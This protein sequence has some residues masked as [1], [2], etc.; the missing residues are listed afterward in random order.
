MNGSKPLDLPRILQMHPDGAKVQSFGSGCSS[1][2]VKRSDAVW[3]NTRDG[4]HHG[5]NESIGGCTQDFTAAGSRVRP[6]HSAEIVRT[7]SVRTTAFR[8]R[9]GHRMSA[10]NGHFGAQCW[11]FS[12]ARHFVSQGADWQWDKSG[13]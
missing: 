4:K 10:R 1:F 5:A 3:S 2:I 11:I 7:V 8:D 12:G 13:K 9:K 6:E